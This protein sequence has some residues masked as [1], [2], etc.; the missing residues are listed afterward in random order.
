MRQMKIAYFID[1]YGTRSETFISSLINEISTINRSGRVY[2]NEYRKPIS[3]N[4]IQNDFLI[5]ETGYISRYRFISK[6]IFYF[7]KLLK[8]ENIFFAW[9]KLKAK[10]ILKK[11]LLKYKPDVAFIHFGNNAI[12]LHDLLK[13]LNIP[14][15][16]HFHG[17]DASKMF[18]SIVYLDNIKK[19]F[20]DAYKL[21]VMSNHIRRRLIIAGCDDDKIKLVPVAKYFEKDLPKCSWEK[22]KKL[23]PSILYIGRLVEKKNPLALL[24]AFKIVKETI[25]DAILTYVGDGPQMTLLQDSIK[26]LNL[27]NSVQVLGALDHNDAMEF[28]KTHWVY[29]QHCC[30]ASNGDQEGFNNTMVEAAS[31]GLPVISTFHDG[32]PENVDHGKT[33]FLVLEYD[34]EDMADKITK[35][36]KNV[37]LAEEIG[38]NGYNK[39][40]NGFSINKR[41]K[42]ILNILESSIIK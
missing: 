3:N 20:R 7:S 12:L 5:K 35:L 26:S 19:V 41:A 27:E 31:C 40:L 33:G 39:Y 38:T 18:A 22:R 34:F 14:F 42:N 25:S 29:A 10:H 28:F 17:V 11:E 2:I 24:H 4:I 9:N 8:N 32:I 30:T 16:V 15:C 23:P 21:I 37:K 13:E 1:V 36:L 6:L